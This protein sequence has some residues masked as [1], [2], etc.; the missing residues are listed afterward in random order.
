MLQSSKDSVA[1]LGMPH[2]ALRALA[3]SVKLSR[4]TERIKSLSKTNQNPIE[5]TLVKVLPVNIF[6]CRIKALT[7]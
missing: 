1:E 3:L 7:I 4:H 5:C 2:R 6:L